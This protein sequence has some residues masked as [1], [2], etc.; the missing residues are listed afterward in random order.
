MSRNYKRR[1]IILDVPLF[2]VQSFVILIEIVFTAPFEGLF[3]LV[4]LLI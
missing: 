3:Q 1:E 2:N 4:Y